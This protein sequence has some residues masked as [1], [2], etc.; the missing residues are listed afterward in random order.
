MQGAATFLGHPL[1]PILVPFPIAFFIGSLACDVI[2]RFRPTDFWKRAALVLIA[3]GIIGGLAAALF[4]FIDY[5][6]L[7]LRGEEKEDA[8]AHMI[9]NLVIVALFV[10]NFFLRRKNPES[11]LGLALSLLGV[12]GL[13]Y[14]GWLGGEMVYKDGLGVSPEASEL[15]GRY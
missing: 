10:V 12:L 3:F 14:S 8:T 7:P 1:H 15:L 4:G 2:F 6:S 5:F 13:L 11:K 9:A